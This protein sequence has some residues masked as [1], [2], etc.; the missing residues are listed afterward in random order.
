M[1]AEHERESIWSIRKD[2]LAWYSVLFPLLWVVGA[3]V[4]AVTIFSRQLQPAEVIGLLIAGIGLVGLSSAVLSLMILAA[5][6]GV[7]R[8]MP[9]FDWAD[10]REAKLRAEA[11]AGS[12]AASKRG[13]ESLVRTGKSEW[14]YVPASAT[15]AGRAP[16]RQVAPATH[17]FATASEE[18]FLR[19]AFSPPPCR[20]FAPLRPVPTERPRLPSSMKMYRPG[21]GDD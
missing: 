9:L 4:Y 18:S 19:G 13:V 21:A 3:I 16:R 2:D 15:A 6:G 12:A 5:K 8:I 14:R 11:R 10:R 17:P 7:R 20:A 1:D